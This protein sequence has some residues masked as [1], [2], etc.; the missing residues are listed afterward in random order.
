MY[1]YIKAS[2][3]FLSPLMVYFTTSAHNLILLMSFYELFLRFFFF[4]MGAMLSQGSY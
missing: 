4:L 2:D 1:I 3:A